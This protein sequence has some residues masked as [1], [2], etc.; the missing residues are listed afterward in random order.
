MIIVLSD[1]AIGAREKRR[2][3]LEAE[4]LCGLISPRDE[5]DQGV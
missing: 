3:N 5:N 4:H 1:D 2:W